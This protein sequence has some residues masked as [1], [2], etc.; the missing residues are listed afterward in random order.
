MD[1]TPL[2][3]VI[4]AVYNG[5]KYLS[6]S[7]Q[8]VLDQTYS[9]FEF[10]II[11]DG[12]FDKT[13][14]ILERFAK[15]DKRIRI[16]EQENKGLAQS[17]NAGIQRAKG[18]FIARMDDD[19]ICYPNRLEVQSRILLNNSNI[20]VCHSLF[21]LID[22][23]GKAI[24]FRKHTG[25]RFSSLQTQW[26][27]LWRNCICHP[28]VMIR[29]DILK[30]HNFLYDVTVICQDYE[31]WCR[32]IDVTD[33]FVIQ[34]PLLLLRKHS[35]SVSSRYNEKYLAEFSGVI[36]KNLDRYIDFKLDDKA[37]RII[38][39]ISGQMYLRGK[40]NT[41]QMEADIV[42]PIF[43]KVTSKFIQLHS[44]NARSERK[45]HHA[46]AQQLIRW[47]QQAWFHNK[48]AAFRFLFSSFFH[49]LHIRHK[50]RKL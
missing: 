30:K 41:D 29:H 50:N 40:K 2:I 22:S 47:A 6:E 17:L 3:S 12:S 8:S 37:L 9:N 36:S 31:L 39:L 46:A 19:D 4:M 48:R 33:F 20:G 27:L 42:L 13:G 1:R 26:T 32:L 28:S 11:N 10:I 18:E 16:I 25:F 34:E 15:L 24:V 43:E 5:D 49:L 14:E 23:E 7:I 21:G 44:I 35:D 38:T 45:I